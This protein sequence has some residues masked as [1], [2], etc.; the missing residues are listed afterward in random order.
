MY[1][2]YTHI[3]T[4]NF[5]FKYIPVQLRDNDNIFMEFITTNRG[6]RALIMKDTNIKFTDEGEMVGF[7][8]L[9]KMGVGEM[10]IIH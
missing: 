1:L 3:T 7:Q 2:S 4:N 8:L 10:R 9:G 5:L 6:T